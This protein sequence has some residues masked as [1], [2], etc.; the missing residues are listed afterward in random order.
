MS[1]DTL[2]LTLAQL[3]PVVGDIKGNA[4]RMLDVWK[5]NQQ[6]ADLVVFPEL[7][8]CGYPP[9]DLVLNTSF[10]NA[11]HAEVDNICVQSKD[12]RAAALI[13]TIWY[14]N[15]TIYNAVLLVNRGQIQ[16]I[17]F[18][19]KLPNNYVF[20]EPRTFESGPL[21]SPISF[22]GH[23]LGVMICEDV[24]H[25]DVPRHLKNC[26]AEIL[27]ATNGS[28][29]HTYQQDERKSVAVEAILETDLDLI[30]LNMVGGQDELA[31]DGRSF[32]MTKDREMQYMAPSFE[33]TIFDLHVSSKNGQTTITV[34]DD[35]P[36]YENKGPL[37]LI[38]DALCM[39]VRDYVR[40]N[41][42]KKVLIGL[43]GGIDSALTAAIAVDALG[44]ENVRCIMLPSEFTSQDSLDDAK[45]CAENLGVAYEIIPIKD[46][47]SSF[48]QAIPNLSGLGHE[49]TQS[50]VR[51][52]ILMAQS[53][54]S[55]E[56]LLTTGNKSEMA[57]GYCTL[58]GDMNGGFNAIKDVYKTDVYRLSE[59]RNE[60]GKSIPERIITKAPSAELRDNQTDQDS[61]P[62]Y[63][64]LDDVLRLLIEYDNVNWDSAPKI[65]QEKRQR[66]LEH[67]EIVDKVARLLKNTEFKRFQAPPGTRIS[68][69]A[70]GRD[71]RYPL[72]NRFVNKI[73]KA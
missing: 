29:F 43:S 66:C 16:D 42:F 52:T 50:R 12:Y 59:W 21:P 20:D 23:K 26:G 72:T 14:E 32:V 38:Y 28:P 44:A 53:N 25:V 19:H 33:E 7:F 61:L 64:L 71:R 69:R 11:M 73:E 35:A 13:P 51:G 17:R 2:R 62:E 15:N 27:I 10:I 63:D 24:W 39:G 68:F 56:M 58:Y 57:V 36:I 34:N 18:K 5:D 70:F 54:M 40:K 3:N 48:E 22:K 8:L 55:G 37:S 4:Q 60:Q 31:F 41:G 9:E 1:S 49:N 65:L 67:P 47:V 46:I 6:A 45:Q 30:Y